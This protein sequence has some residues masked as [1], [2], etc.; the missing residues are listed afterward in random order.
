MS[1]V[2]V[3]ISRS[4]C[5]IKEG[6]PRGTRIEDKL[7]RGKVASKGGRA[8][9]RGG[10]VSLTNIEVSET[11]ARPRAPFVAA[12]GRKV[13]SLN[14]SKCLYFSLASIF[15]RDPR[16]IP[17]LYAPN[18]AIFLTC[19]QND[20]LAHSLFNIFPCAPTLPFAPLPPLR[21]YSLVHILYVRSSDSRY[22]P[23]LFCHSRNACPPLMYSSIG[24]YT[25]PWV[26]RHENAAVI[27]HVCRDSMS[28]GM[29]YSLFHLNPPWCCFGAL[30]CFG[31]ISHSR[32]NYITSC[33]CELPD[34]FVTARRSEGAECIY[35]INIITVKWSKK[36]YTRKSAILS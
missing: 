20:I 12:Q 34:F 33:F 28:R 18:A 13:L 3:P 7:A 22:R 30:E 35:F 23:L 10:T 14:L 6:L 4:L 25:A 32:L 9:E 1:H 26:S 29:G 11:S 17:P 8:L 36:L 31:S 19:P 21:I 2:Y 16:Q 15:P 27:M 24:A 5:L